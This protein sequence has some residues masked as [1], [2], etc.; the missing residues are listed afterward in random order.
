MP[1]ARQSDASSRPSVGARGVCWAPLAPAAGRVG[2]AG[3]AGG[4]AAAGRFGACLGRRR[5]PYGLLDP[6]APPAVRR[7]STGEASGVLVHDILMQA[8]RPL[9]RGDRSPGEGGLR[10]STIAR[11]QTAAGFGDG[12]WRPPRESGGPRRVAEGGGRCRRARSYD[13]SRG[14]GGRPSRRGGR[15]G[16]PGGARSPYRVRPTGPGGGP[17]GGRGSVGRVRCRGVLVR[18]GG[19][20][21][22][23]GARV[24][25]VRE[26]W[27]CD[28]ARWS[29]EGVS[30]ET[31]PGPGAIDS[32]L[33]RQPSARIAPVGGGLA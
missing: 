28:V 19:S 17:G 14:C 2:G 1:D 12:L 11:S 15:T 27:G 33:N 9:P 24:S 30:R 22:Q 13:G 20:T 5:R 21:V 18:C 16:A 3:E 25:V 7:W 31:C 26:A 32:I 10:R 29:A 23:R 4:A 8:S 6:L